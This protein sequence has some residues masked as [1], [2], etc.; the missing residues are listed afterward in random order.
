MIAPTYLAYNRPPNSKPRNTTNQ[1]KGGHMMIIW[2]ENVSN[3]AA[4][5][6][7]IGDLEDI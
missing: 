4:G 2:N 1:V 5:G 7:K 3:S 6:R